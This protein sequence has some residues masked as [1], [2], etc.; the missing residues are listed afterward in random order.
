MA[1]VQMRRNPAPCCAG[2]QGYR[3]VMDLLVDGGAAMIHYAHLRQALVF[4]MFRLV[5]GAREQ[6]SG[7]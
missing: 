1:W 4:M 5:L 6:H 3:G 2:S 7:R